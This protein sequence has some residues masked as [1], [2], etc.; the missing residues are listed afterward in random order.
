MKDKEGQELST[1]EVVEKVGNRVANVGLETGVFL[2]HLAGYVPSHTVRKLIYRLGG[3][4]IGKRS[5][6]HMGAVFYDPRQI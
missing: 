4:R 5:T 3:V 2:L 1:Q 6:I